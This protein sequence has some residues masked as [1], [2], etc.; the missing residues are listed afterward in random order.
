[1]NWP[2]VLSILTHQHVP[3]DESTWHTMI[4]YPWESSCAVSFSGEE[5]WVKQRKYQ[6]QRILR[7]EKLDLHNSKPVFSCMDQLCTAPQ[8]KLPSGGFYPSGRAETMVPAFGALGNWQ[9]SVFASQQRQLT[10]CPSEKSSHSTSSQPLSS[11]SSVEG[12]DQR[13]RIRCRLASM[14]VA[15][16]ISSCVTHVRIQIR[17]GFMELL[18]VA[19]SREWPN[20]RMRLL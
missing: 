12:H 18:R 20:F 1:M 13:R 7:S 6:V 11:L 16:V 9:N 15:S 3:Y 14:T 10:H 4:L 5:W 2:V 17:G 8:K 19:S